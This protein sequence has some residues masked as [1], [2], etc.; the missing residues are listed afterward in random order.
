M[1]G[2]RQVAEA[3]GTESGVSVASI[4]QDTEWPPEEARRNAPP[5]PRAGEMSFL[6]SN[7]ALRP[8]RGVAS[9]ESTKQGEVRNRETFLPVLSLLLSISFLP[10]LRHI[11][12]TYCARALC[13]G[14]Q[15]AAKRVCRLNS[16]TSQSNEERGKDKLL[17]QPRRTCRDRVGTARG[18]GSTGK[19]GDREGV[20]W[21]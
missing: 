9:G 17:F 19:G 15:Q 4:P 20:R 2:K 14:Q 5:G 10:V 8:P 3:V 11:L 12:N 1:R 6:P 18:C 21:S 13:P 7:L 16:R